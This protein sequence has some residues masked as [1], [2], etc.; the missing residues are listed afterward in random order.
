MRKQKTLCNFQILSDTD[1]NKIKEYIPQALTEVEHLVVA[2]NRNG[3]PIAFMGTNGSRLEM[4]FISPCEQGKG[5][6]K[7]LNEYGK[8]NYG[9]NEVTV[10][11]Q[12]LQAV[13]FYKHIGFIT[14]KRPDLDEQGNP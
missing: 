12:N 5:Y 10:N 3:D 9:I 1:I 14:Y 8:N 13:G 2:E 4:L 6:G 7:K 11:E